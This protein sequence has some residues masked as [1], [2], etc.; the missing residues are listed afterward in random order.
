MVNK[1]K[2]EI[3]KKKSHSIRTIS[4][5]DLQHIF[6]QVY[7]IKDLSKKP[8]NL[9]DF[10]KKLIKPHLQVFITINFQK[11]NLRKKLINIEV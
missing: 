2:I 1:L 7:K 10:L 4:V 3:H 5:Q 6:K 11:K 9:W 8:Q